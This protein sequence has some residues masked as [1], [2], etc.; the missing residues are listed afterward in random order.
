MCVDKT[1]SKTLNQIVGRAEKLLVSCALEL[2]VRQGKVIE[3]SGRF[4]NK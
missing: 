4:K 1:V 2:L 3:S